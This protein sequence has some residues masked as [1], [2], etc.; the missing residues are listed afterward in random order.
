MNIENEKV[1]SLLTEIRDLLVP[2]SAS[3]EKEY[4]GTR[5]DELDSLLST[6]TKRRIYALLF[7]NR[8]LS[9]TAIA[10]EAKTTQPTVSRLI[11]SLL[12]ASLIEKHTDENGQDFYQDKYNLSEKLEA[13]N[14]N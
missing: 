13:K 9:Q 2:I 3:F 10:K 8:K 6:E 14:D 7:D 12:E 5:I 11:T 1:V 4:I